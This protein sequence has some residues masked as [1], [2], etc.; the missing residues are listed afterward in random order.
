MYY[1]LFRWVLKKA[2]PS[3][4]DWHLFPDTQDSIEW[5]TMQDVLDIAG[6]GFEPLPGFVHQGDHR[7]GHVAEIGSQRGNVVV[8]LFRRRIEDVIF[9]QGGQSLGLVVWYRGFHS[10]LRVLAELLARGRLAQCVI[11]PQNVGGE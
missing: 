11:A 10:I 5:D 8:G 6:L 4:L 2:W 1:H 9:P 7:D 3:E